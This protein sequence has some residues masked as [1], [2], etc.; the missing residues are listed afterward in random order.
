VL[1]PILTMLASGLWHGTNWTF[2][3]WGALHGVFLV[4]SILWNRATVSSWVPFSLPPQVVMGLN[5]F[6][7]FNLVCFAWVFFRA[8]SI[9]DAL[10]IIRHLFVNQEINA[11]LFGLMPLG[12]YDWLIALLAIITMEMVQ[13]GQRKYSSLREVL[14]RQPVWLRWSVYYALIVVIF[15]F[16]KFG[17]GE[18]IYARF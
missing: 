15:M 8:N 4:S 3:V 5:I 11:S 1:P 10:Y 9:S 14:R 13:Y 16:G 12:W 6:I 18:F 7:T 17:S 2:L